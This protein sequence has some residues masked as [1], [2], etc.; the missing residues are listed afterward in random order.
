MTSHTFQ[1]TI[2]EL[3]TIIKSFLYTTIV[4][5][6]QLVGCL[7]L[8]G[9]LFNHYQDIL[10]CVLNIE[11][12]WLY[13]SWAVPW[14]YLWE[15]WENALLVSRGLQGFRFTQVNLCSYVDKGY[16]NAT[17]SYLCIIIC[18]THL[19]SW[20]FFFKSNETWV[21]QLPK[22]YGWFICDRH[23]DGHMDGSYV[24]VHMWS[25]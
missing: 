18:K 24:I 15:L 17:M 21:N 19:S 8:L 20:L 10:E 3:I 23:V 5:P 1:A 13:R 12:A 25:T 7:L 4:D 22:T 6:H 9:F 11:I 16:M 14:F 2:L